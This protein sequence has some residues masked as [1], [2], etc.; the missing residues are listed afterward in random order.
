[1]K[2]YIR[3]SKVYDQKGMW[4]NLPNTTEQ[5]KWLKEQLE[6]ISQNQIHFFQEEDGRIRIEL[7]EN[8]NIHTLY[9]DDLVP[10]EPND[11]QVQYEPLICKCCGAPIN[12]ETMT[13]E[14]CGTQYGKE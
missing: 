6:H 9:V 10:T 11:K 7:P 12:R 13:C 4:R 2:G 1:M 8:G 5:D 3:M 14:Y